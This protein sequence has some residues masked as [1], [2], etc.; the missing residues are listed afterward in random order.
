MKPNRRYLDA[1][2]LF[3][4]NMQRLRKEQRVSQ[5]KLAELAGLHRTYI[6][7]VERQGRNITID[8]MEQIALALHVPIHELLMPISGEIE[9]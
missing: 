2:T 4:L 7:S 5:E 3:S 1:R 9:Q 8:N 6:S